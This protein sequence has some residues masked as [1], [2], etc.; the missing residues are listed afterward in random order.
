MEILKGAASALYGSEAV[1]GVINI[2]T[3]AFSPKKESGQT[4]RV[5]AQT[6]E[7]RLLNG[8]AYGNWSNGKTTLTGGLLS[9]NSDGQAQR[10]TRGSFHLHTL[11][12]AASRQWKND[13][14]AA[15]RLSADWR[16]FG[17]QNFYTTFAS[18][19]AREEVNS[20]W[21]QFH[22]Q[23]KKDRSVFSA[24]AS[25]KLLRDQYWFRPT[26]L[27]NDNKSNLLNLQALYT[28]L[29]GASFTYTVGVQALHRGIRSN[30]R[31]DHSLWHGAVFAITR[32]RFTNNVYMNESL[33]LD[34]D[35]SYGWVI[36]PQWNIAWSP[37]K[38][39]L[40]A[41]AGRSF[42]DADFTERYNNYKKAQVTSGRIGNPGLEAE[43][44]W[45]GELGADYF[46]NQ[47]LKISATVF[48]RAHRRLIDWVNTPYSQM[49]RTAN[50]VPGGTYALAKNAER[51]NT[52]GAELDLVWERKL[53][54]HSLLRWTS[55][56]SWLRSKNDDSLPSFYIS[57]HAKFLANF[58]VM[59]IRKNLSVSLTGLY[60]ERQEQK[61]AA[62]S[63]A[64]SPRYFTLNA[65]LALR[66]PGDHGLIF[67]QADN[68]F[69]KKYS[70]LLGSPL[71]GRWLSGGIEIAL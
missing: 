11:S 25:L 1:G 60:K 21:T 62:L 65:R 40:R 57:A 39:T 6:G 13:W 12:L 58:S 67:L 3:R 2:I 22:L 59:L 55:G 53:D 7:Y 51:V 64:V 31:G 63:A 42:R 5:R 18:D 15:L 35:E 23:R 70:D 19:T 8:E 17:A 38:L 9:N 29:P 16:K 26:A 43:S 49:P 27:P 37:S 24:D 32:H 41:S 52:S 46:L 66:C 47:E 34:G 56:L 61:A 44:S 50:L 54:R 14:M 10:G 33:R 36:V 48:Y 71:P 69:D 30:D 4:F 68:V 28:R 45:N 20:A